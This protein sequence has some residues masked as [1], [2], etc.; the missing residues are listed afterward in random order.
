MR[1]L[2]L[3]NV[4][5]GAIGGA[6]VQALRLARC[7]A[8][9]GHPVIIAG[10]ENLPNEDVGLSVLRT[11]LL[12]RTRILRGFSY[13]ITIMWFLWSRRRDYD[14]IYCRF[15][16]EQAFVAALARQ[17]FRLKQPLVACPACSGDIG[18]VAWIKKSPLRGLLLGTFSRGISCINA[19]SR[20]IQQE[21]SDLGLS[22]PRLS[23]LPNGVTVPAI[24]FGRE[25]DNSFLRAIFVG[26]LVR[27]KGLD[28]LLNAVAML[29]HNR[30][31]LEIMIVGD[32]PLRAELEVLKDTLGLSETV[33]F[34]GA[35]PPEKI[36][37]LLSYANIFVLPSRHEG[38]PGVVLEA[39]AQGLPAIVTRCG[40][41]EIVDESI[42]WVVPTENTVALAGALDAA[43]ALG[44]VS[45]RIMG[46][47]AHEKARR[48]YESGSIAERHIELFK[49]LIAASC[50]E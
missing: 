45:L 26:R 15:L 27:Q 10:P 13:A 14:L 9:T 28:I 2:I 41:A 49:E 38:M 22:R 30:Q 42:G 33:H 44:P 7:W 47:R 17:L 6:E 12:R 8:A 21:I 50:T 20:N 40:G 24:I 39:I 5:P 37:E 35:V 23:T 25:D 1:I 43:I 3:A 32:G 4:P 16:K 29:R 46:E 18:D 11:P 31:C 36:P 19:M 48:N 34:A